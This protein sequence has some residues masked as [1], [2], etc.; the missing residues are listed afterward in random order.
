MSLRLKNCCRCNS[1]GKCK[2]CSCVKSGKSCRNC[3][4]LRLSHCLNSENLSPIP[5][6]TTNTSS[7]ST[8]V[9]DHYTTSS[10]TTSVGSSGHDYCTLVNIPPDTSSVVTTCPDYCTSVNTS[11]DISSVVTSCPDYCTSV[12]IPPDTSSV[13]TSYPNY[14]TSVNTSPNTSSVVTS[15]PDYC[16]SVNTSPNTSSVVTSCPDYCTSVNTS[17]NTSSVVMSITDQNTTISNTSSNSLSISS[18][19]TSHADPCITRDKSHDTSINHVDPL[20]SFVPA[21]IPNF[22]LGEIDG[23]TMQG[24]INESYNEIV[25][26]KRNLF[27]V[28]SGKA[29]KGFVRELTRLLNAFAE[30]SALEVIALKAAFV[31]PALLL[32]KPHKRFKAKEHS[33][34]LERRLGLWNNGSIDALLKEGRTIQKQFR[35]INHKSS[36]DL[37]RAFAK[38]LMEGKVKKALNLLSDYSSGG[39]MCP[40]EEIMTKL[41]EKHPTRQPPKPSATLSL[42]HK[43][44]TI[45]HPI[46]FEQIDAQLI[47]KTTLQMDGAAGPSGLDAGAWKRLCSSFGACSNDLCSAVAAVAKRLCTA[48]VDPTCISALVAGRL[49]ALDKCP[50]IRPIGIGET[51]CRIIARAISYVLRE[52]IK[53]AAGPLQLCAGQASGCETAIHAIKEIMDEPTNDAV[54][55]VDASNAF[56]N[57]NSETA[58]RNISVLCPSLATVVINTYRSDIQMFIG[59]ETVLSQEGTTQGDPLA[60][61]MYAIATT[62]LIQ[63]LRNTNTH[64]IWYADDASATS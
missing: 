35:N 12:N 27:K 54:L 36:E 19:I 22:R 55:I 58:M 15:C 29:G 38:L 57:L 3:L 24:V 30:V 59:D 20:P 2:N 18:V 14:C 64:Q 6:T 25:H 37:P 33:S 56:N 4:P 52:D 60:M 23:T 42:D 13:V 47:H 28:P 5:L 7:L 31:M 63:Q 34:H 43:A 53:T 39:P 11:P 1:N 16:T 51:L 44:T 40:N 10:N 45:H 21:Q 8:T 48:Y 9:V 50:G 49:I 62:P 41:R 17:S 61:A 26:W 32:Q 46:I